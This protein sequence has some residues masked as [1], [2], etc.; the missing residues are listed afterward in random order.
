MRCGR[1]IRRC[2]NQSRHLAT[3]I[4]LEHV[5]AGIE[6]AYPFPGTP[7]VVL[8]IEGAVPRL[9]LRIESDD[10][11]PV[12][13]NTL[14]HVRVSSISTEETQFLTVAVSGSELVLDGHAMLC[15]IADRVQLEHRRP[16][17]AI[18]E[19][20]TQWRSVL[21]ARSRMSNEGEIGLFGELLALES[22]H[23]AIGSAAVDAWRGTENEEHDFGLN[24]IDVEIKTTAGERRTH[25]ISG[26]RQL[27]PSVDRPLALVSVQ[28]TRGGMTGRT[29][30][31]L[32][33]A[34]RSA[35]DDVTQFDAKLARI[36]WEDAA[37]DLY[38][39]RWAL[40][41]HPAAFEISGDFPRL[42]PALLSTLPVDD[43]SLVDVRYRIDLD[44]RPADAR[45]IANA[46]AHP[47]E[48]E[49][50]RAEHMSAGP[51]IGDVILVSL[52]AMKN[53][54][55]MP[56]LK[57]I[58]LEA[59]MHGVALKS[60]AEALAAVLDEADGD[61]RLHG[62]LRQELAF[63]DAADAAAWTNGTT[64][65]TADRRESIYDALQLPEYMRTGWTELFPIA[66]AGGDVVISTEFEPWYAASLSSRTPFYWQHYEDYL[67][68]RGWHPDAIAA[69]GQATTRV[70]ERL[71][72]PEREAA[73]QSKGLVVGYVQ[74]GKTANFTGVIA[75]AID[76]G[77]R[78][79]IVLTGTTD[80]L[81]AQTQRRLDKELV[82]QENILRGVEP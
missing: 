51:T 29:L 5:A 7:A 27:L 2:L 48:N 1:R 59:E 17:E 56:L 41:S 24:E 52:D 75:K 58:G 37:A 72:D 50:I 45:H 6:I 8:R 14:Q 39:E 28:V 19:T 15:A 54:G 62:R 20:V 74:S 40:R 73:Y 64:P 67:I 81:R 9:T 22:L 69:L 47:R 13:L 4:L 26:V 30:A 80:L 53:T 38:I 57:R 36:G 32:V 49:V 44:G 21:A 3:Q 23:A 68:A 42:T 12:A 55:P 33:D 79:I 18:V 16:G 25:W 43:E 66:T 60:P 76:A 31:E 78:L 11:A 71:A 65:K 77:Y 61:S 82:G 35:V 63:W 70:V 46:P 10:P 34:L